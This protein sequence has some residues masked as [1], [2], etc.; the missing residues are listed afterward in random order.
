MHVLQLGVRLHKDLGAGNR[1]SGGSRG[2]LIYVGCCQGNVLPKDF[3][4]LLKGREDLSLAWVSCNELRG[5]SFNS[6][7]CT[8]QREV[9]CLEVGISRL[10]YCPRERGGWSLCAHSFAGFYTI[11]RFSFASIIGT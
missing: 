3:C 11:T 4:L 8:S 1:A 6:E 9:T 10:I 5:S 2:P 7:W